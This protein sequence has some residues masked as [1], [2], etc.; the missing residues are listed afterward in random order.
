MRCGLRRARQPGASCPRAASTEVA[1]GSCDLPLGDYAGV[2][3]RWLPIVLVGLLA[4]VALPGA[5]A[6]AT[7]AAD[8]R[9]HDNGNSSAT[10]LPSPPSPL[11]N[12]AVGGGPANVFQ[13]T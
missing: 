6:G 3:R 7:L 11:A 8:Y 13:T 12:I 2:V 1:Q 9:F 10:E 5:A 4:V